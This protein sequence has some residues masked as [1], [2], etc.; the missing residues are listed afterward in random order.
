[1]LNVGKVAGYVAA[2]VAEQVKSPTISIECRMSPMIVIMMV[3]MS[4]ARLAVDLMMID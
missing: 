1:M 2:L 4:A 3:M